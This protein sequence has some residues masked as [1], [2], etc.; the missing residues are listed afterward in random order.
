MSGALYPESW[1]AGCGGV[2]EDMLEMAESMDEFLGM[3]EDGPSWDTA[4]AADMVGFEPLRCASPVFDIKGSDA[5]RLSLILVGE[6][7]H[8]FKV[9]SAW[10]VRR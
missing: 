9:V 8:T 2:C 3:T 1:D 6:C 5:L 10:C 7:L 4:T